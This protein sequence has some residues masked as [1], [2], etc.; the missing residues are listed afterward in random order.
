MGV[1]RIDG[2]DIIKMLKVG[3][4]IL[5]K[6][7]ARVDSLNVFPV[8]DGD[9]GTNMYLTLVSAIREAEKQNDSDAGKVGKAIAT[10]SLMGARGNSGVILSQVFRGFAREL[11]GKPIVDAPILA[12][13][14][15]SG[16]E[17]AYKAVIKP[18]EGTILT[19][20][21]EVARSAATVAHKEE[22]I[23]TVMQEAL[24]AG[25]RMLEKTPTML[26]ILKEAGV[27]DAGGQGFLFILQGMIEALTGTSFY[28][29]TSPAQR[30]QEAVISSGTIEC[31]YCTEVLVKGIG[32]K[33]EQMRKTLEVLGDSLLVVGEEDLVK[34][35]VHSK[36]PGKVLETCLNWGSL[37]DIKIDNLEEQMENRQ[38]QE[39]RSWKKT[40][41][42]AVG[43]GD[44]WKE[45]L[46]S[47][48]VDQIVEG[49]QTMNPSTED[50]LKAVEEVKAQSVVVFPNNKNVILAANQA[51][52]LSDRIIRVVP[53]TSVVQT[54]SAMMV[55]D[56]ETDINKIAE[57]MTEE[58]GKVR[59][60]EVTSAVRDSGVN[61]LKI[62][63]GDYIGLIDDKVE[64]KGNNLDEV[65]F[66]TIEFIN[67]GGELI[68]LYYGHD[69]DSAQAEQ[70][71][72]RIEKKYL[73]QDVE[74]HYGGQPFY[75][76]LI[77]I[78]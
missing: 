13:A 44:G 36:N 3:C 16:S 5:E 14:L 60:G 27:V 4:A 63:V 75:H 71:K 48:G 54:I 38:E 24:T 70:L 40:G 52:E 30:I 47:L 49:G 53:T 65:V 58:I 61:G 78:E 39:I 73:M 18:V 29:S 12:A 26:P 22:D 68:C 2:Q 67:N 45:I 28:P 50:I 17:T 25:S 59:I 37:H 62:K 57:V 42:V 10:G 55:Y 72:E 6:N 21:R 51:S 11:E 34:V 56:S 43:M 32:L 20:V 8:P 1:E 7:K 31:A 66:E 9:T 76:Y 19:I 15:H 35:H 23:I 64:V 46:E 33:I 41:V 69:V 77:S 74:L